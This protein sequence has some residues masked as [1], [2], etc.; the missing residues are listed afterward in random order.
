MKVYFYNSEISYFI[1]EFA[2]VIHG[3]AIPHCF[4]SSRNVK[5]IFIYISAKILKML[6]ESRGSYPVLS[7]N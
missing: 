5:N 3:V 1:F 6:D 4:I 7:I 2:S